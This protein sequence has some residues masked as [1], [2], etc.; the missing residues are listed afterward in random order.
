MNN[1]NGNTLVL[2]YGVW[3]ERKSLIAESFDWEKILANAVQLTQNE[4]NNHIFTAK[5]TSSFL[6]TEKIFVFIQAV[7][8]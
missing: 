2:V 5:I 1:M 4:F 7:L 8:R 3:P 6:H